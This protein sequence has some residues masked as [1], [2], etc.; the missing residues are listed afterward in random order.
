MRYI[1]KIHTYII[2][3]YLWSLMLLTDL[4]EVVLKIVVSYESWVNLVIIALV[5]QSVTPFYN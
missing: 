3:R 4:R 1:C 5:F 2:D